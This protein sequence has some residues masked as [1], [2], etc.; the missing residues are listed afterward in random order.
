MREEKKMSEIKKPMTM[1]EMLDVLD[2]F[3]VEADPYDARCVWD[4]LTAL[5][6]PDDAKEHPLSKVRGTVHVRAAAFPRT[7]AIP[8][9][10]CLADFNTG[11]RPF[12]RKDFP[13]SFDGHLDHFAR[14]IR[15]AMLALGILKDGE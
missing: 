14:H 8:S 3:F 15:L 10:A 11:E 5:R 6:G 7:A 1:R 4:V 13:Q 2:A 9:R 12:T